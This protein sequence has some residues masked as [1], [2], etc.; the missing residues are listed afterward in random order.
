MAS[1]IDS[2][3]QFFQRVDD[4]KIS[5]QVKSLLKDAGICSFG[6]M[7]Y[8]HGRPGQQIADRDYE[9]W[10]QAK[11]DP[12]GSLSDVANVKRLLFEAQTLVLASLKDQITS[13]E[14]TVK[15]VPAAERDSRMQVVRQ[16]LAG[17][18]IE[19]S[20]ESSH[21]LLDACASMH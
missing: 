7:G 21:V 14:T 12:A 3:A 8:G 13:S 5:R 10:F 19:G 1:L 9:A 20:L 11:L 18:L 16:Q 17:L 4:L 15:K 2:E 6:T